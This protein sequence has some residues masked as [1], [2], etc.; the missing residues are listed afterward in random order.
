MSLAIATA[1]KS[2]VPLCIDEPVGEEKRGK[3]K[4]RV[5]K[6]NKMDIWR[7]ERRDK[8][9]EKEGGRA[10]TVANEEDAFREGLGRVCGEPV[11]RQ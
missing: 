6:E 9:R 11:A 2:Q 1:E 8:I 7:E 5:A 10:G 4:K 3:A